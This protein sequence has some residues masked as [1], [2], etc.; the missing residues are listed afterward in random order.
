MGRNGKGRV[1]T[2][3]ALLAGHNKDTDGHKIWKA[4]SKSSIFD[5]MTERD[6]ELVEGVAQELKLEE[7]AWDTKTG[8]YDG[9]ST[10][11]GAIGIASS[12]HERGE[13]DLQSLHAFR[14]SK[15]YDSLDSI[16]QKFPDW[17]KEAL[18]S[19]PEPKVPNVVEE[20]TMELNDIIADCMDAANAVMLGYQ[21]T[22][23]RP[24]AD[25]DTPFIMSDYRLQ[26]LDK[27]KDLT[28]RVTEAKARLLARHVEMQGT[29]MLMTKPFYN[30]MK[31]N[32]ELLSPENAP[33]CE[34]VECWEEH[35]PADEISYIIPDLNATEVR[36]KLLGNT[37][38]ITPFIDQGEEVTQSA[39]HPQMHASR[40]APAMLM[41]TNAAK[42]ARAILE[43]N[44]NARPCVVDMGAGA[45]GGEKLLTLKRDARNAGIYVHAAIPS[46]DNA[47]HDRVARMRLN[48]TFISWNN[49]S[50]TH[51]V[52]SK[53]LNWCSHK[54]RDCNCLARYT[55]VFVLCVHSVYYF[56]QRDFENIFKYTATFES[57][58]HIPSVGNTVP[59][60]KPEYVWED[61]SQQGSKAKY[62]FWGRVAAGVKAA[63]TQTT[64][65]RLQPLVTAA[66]TY[67][68][69]DNGER[70]RRGGFHPNTWTRTVDDVLETNGK[71]AAFA[72][73]VA[74]AGAVGGLLG[75]LGKSALSSIG[76]AA[77]GAASSL[78]MTTAAATFVKWDSMQEA[79]W[80]PGQ[81]T[82]EASIASS[83][84]NPEQEQLAHI[85]RYARLER[86]TRLEPRVIES[87]QV[88]RQEVGRVAAA[89]LSAN[90]T[91][92]Q[93]RSQ[94]MMSAV[95]LRD[96]KP[97][98]LIKGTIHQAKRIADFLFPPPP[99]VRR[100]PWLLKG[101]LALL[102]QPLVSGLSKTAASAT[103]A[104]LCPAKWYQPAKI[105]FLLWNISPMTVIYLLCAAPLHLVGLWL[106]VYL[107]DRM[108]SD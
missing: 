73:G 60:D 79:P 101:S 9:S 53:R 69:P 5:E 51:Q 11:I 32:S 59:T 95:L 83:Y 67:H 30:L 104:A 56:T 41:Y 77:Y 27:I 93:T 4:I 89:L 48:P 54:A 82:V 74:T 78:A 37:K 70:I 20:A 97:A 98:K 23:V 106:V 50:V 86:G 63:V 26:C 33:L 8:A 68:H 72:L 3:Q 49:V 1:F 108:L 99:D 103:A 100:P 31:N 14:R 87:E 44:P 15:L 57:L 85:V 76:A 75:S 22:F 52:S 66:T 43:A 94:R 34:T 92:Q 81:Y 17:K 64:Q 36:K 90:D 25:A 71:L 102:C 40:V 2:K 55:H 18:F 62:G 105:T 88:D 58:E 6:K 24:P 7:L 29:A 13:K 46:V 65:V 39:S 96:G 38:L 16:M 28:T 107:S 12:S 45:F 84:Q 35:C 47:D 19:R 61:A 21:A 91:A 80:L 42:K 10:E